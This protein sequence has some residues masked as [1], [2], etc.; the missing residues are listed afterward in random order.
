ML[1]KI[2]NILN[3]LQQ[4]LQGIYKSIFRDPN[5]EKIAKYRMSVCSTCP[6]QGY[7][8]NINTFNISIKLFKQC[9][10]CHCLLLL[11]SHSFNIDKEKNATCPLGLWAI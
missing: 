8:I 4:I 1:K 2:K 11:K 10:Q 3:I 5:T 7:L 9:K 6:K